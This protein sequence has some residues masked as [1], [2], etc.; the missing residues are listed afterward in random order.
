ME[1]MSLPSTS[2]QPAPAV[3]GE[4]L[5]TLDR[6]REEA[7]PADA[8]QKWELNANCIQLV[9]WCFE[10]PFGCPSVSWVPISM[11]EAWAEIIQSIQADGPSVGFPHGIKADGQKHAWSWRAFQ[12]ASS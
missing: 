6:I 9:R 3:E 4:G 5:W 1:Q 12:F 2:G 8:Q 11:K 10:T 7:T